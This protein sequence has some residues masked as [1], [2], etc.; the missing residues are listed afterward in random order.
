MV[1]GES[2]CWTLWYQGFPA[3]GLPGAKMAGV[4]EESA[5][6]GVGQVYIVQEPDAAGAT[7]VKAIANRLQKWR[8]EGKAPVGHLSHAKDPNELYK[9]NPKGFR[10]A[11]QP[12]PDHPQPPFFPPSHPVYLPPLAKPNLS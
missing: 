3:M 9:Q 8:W 10:P 7:F 5:L 2:D 11:F 12:P 6:T 4:V 1:E